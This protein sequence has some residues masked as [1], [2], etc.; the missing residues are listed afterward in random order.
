[1]KWAQVLHAISH[2]VDLL[3]VLIRLAKAT[4][5]ITPKQ[6]LEVQTLLQEIG[7]MGG[8]WLNFV[9][10]Q[11]A[12]CFLVR[13][14]TEFPATSHTDVVVGIEAGVGPDNEARRL[15]APNDGRTCC[16][17]NPIGVTSIRDYTFLL[18]TNACIVCKDIGPLFPRVLSYK[19]WARS[20]ID[21]ARYQSP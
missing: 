11:S 13:L 3:K 7:K 14:L 1:V 16:A 12:Q 2:N 10:H 8:D 21:R 19:A 5:A 15:E 20:S 18:A 17:P 6:Y 4:R 9:A